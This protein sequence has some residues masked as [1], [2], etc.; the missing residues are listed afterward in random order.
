LRNRDSD[1]IS[2]MFG[3]VSS[4]HNASLSSFANVY[5]ALRDQ[6]SDKARYANVYFIDRRGGVNQNKLDFSREPHYYITTCERR[7]TLAEAIKVI[8]ENDEFIFSLLHGQLGEDGHF[9]GISKAIGIRGTFGSVL[10]CSLSMSKYHMAQYVTATHPQIEPIPTVIIDE[11]DLGVLVEKLRPFFNTEVVIKPNSLGA[12]LFTARFLVDAFNLNDLREHLVNVLRYDNMALVQRYID[13]KE[14]SCGCIEMK[15]TVVVLPLVHI[16]TEGNF[17]GHAEKHQ[18]GKADEILVPDSQLDPPMACIKEVSQE[19][20][21]KLMFENMC[22]FDFIISNRKVYFLEANPI[23][24]LMKNSIFP[25]ML[26]ARD[27]GVHELP[28]IFLENSMGRK[29]KETLVEYDIAE[30]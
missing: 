10:S 3:G 23:P 2:L 28:A 14:Y 21:E 4:E 5:S 9:Q 27:I 24:G 18:K 22:R 19:I 11:R 26:K 29:S 25:K 17:F 7:H 15:N 30:E 16:Q 6:A 20:F 1:K 12:S 8:R 13:G